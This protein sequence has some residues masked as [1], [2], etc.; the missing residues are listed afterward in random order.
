MNTFYWANTIAFACSSLRRLQI[1]FKLLK[2]QSSM[3]N[4]CEKV[5]RSAQEKH[6]PHKQLVVQFQMVFFLAGRL[7]SG[8]FVSLSK[9]SHYYYD[10]PDIKVYF[11]LAYL[12]FFFVC[13]A[14]E[15]P[16][17]SIHLFVLPS[18]S[19]IFDL[20]RRNITAK[21]NRRQTSFPGRS[22]LFGYFL[23]AFSLLVFCFLLNVILSDV[24]KVET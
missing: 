12:T 7:K 2:V 3:K 20:P 10:F 14:W 4:L 11:P 9:N 22:L 16:G 1:G 13:D 24:A 21:E 6:L 19:S 18:H 17:P 15:M 23:L 5:F 8:K